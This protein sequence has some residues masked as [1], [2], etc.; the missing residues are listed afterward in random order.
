[1]TALDA[2]SGEELWHR[3]ST[4]NQLSCCTPSVADGI[5][6]AGT[7]AGGFYAYDAATGEQRWGAQAAGVVDNTPA[8]AEGMVFVGDSH[9][10]VYAVNGN[11]GGLIWHLPNRYGASSPVICGS[12]GWI[13]GATDGRGLFKLGLSTGAVLCRHALD[14][15][16]A[17]PV[18][19]DGVIYVGTYAGTVLGLDAESG[20]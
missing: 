4:A 14:G 1:M 10:G 6:C 18:L 2:A 17:G 5:V 7:G 13:V 20:R 11:D 15:S 8:L 9:G 3:G 12:H 16:G 19:A